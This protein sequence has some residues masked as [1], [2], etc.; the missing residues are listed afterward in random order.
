M[1]TMYSTNKS[2]SICTAND[3]SYVA[4]WC[5]PSP[6]LT[7]CKTSLVNMSLQFNIIYIRGLKNIASYALNF[8]ASWTLHLPQCQQS[9]PNHWFSAGK[10]IDAFYLFIYMSASTIYRLTGFQ[11]NV[12]YAHY[13][14]TA[15]QQYFKSLQYGISERTCHV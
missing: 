11:E 13:S 9:G 4:C 8:S 14:S 10:T 6:Y 3:Q 2:V 5:T 12:Y 1:I 7:I 15:L